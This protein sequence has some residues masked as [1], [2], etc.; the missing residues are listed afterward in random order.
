[1]LRNALVVLALLT[2]ASVPPAHADR[3]SKINLRV[4][5]ATL[6]DG[7]NFIHTFNSRG[8]MIARAARNKIIGYD[9][10]TITRIRLPMRHT[11][12]KKEILEAPA[13]AVEMDCIE[14]R[15]SCFFQGNLKMKVCDTVCTKIYDKQTE[16]II[17]V[18]DPEMIYVTISSEVMDF[19]RSGHKSAN[20]KMLEK[21][22]R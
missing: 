8:R 6:E 11:E 2:I 10:D 21:R 15:E 13:G 16:T 19:S 18:T 20:P 1:M 7:D 22:K 17:P 3:K 9:I 4:T 12:T 5:A 14:W